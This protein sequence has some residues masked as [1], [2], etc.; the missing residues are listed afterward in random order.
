MKIVN[1]QVR[2]FFIG[3]EKAVCPVTDRL[4]SGGYVQKGGYVLTARKAGVQNPTQ[5]WHL[6]HSWCAQSGDNAPFNKRIQCGELLIWMAEVS[7]AV[8]EKE[9]NNLCDRILSDYKKTRK[10]IDRA[11][12]KW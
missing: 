4:V 9:L 10:A 7:G 11:E 8:S 1:K 6:I 3:K 5:Y 12:E 2:E